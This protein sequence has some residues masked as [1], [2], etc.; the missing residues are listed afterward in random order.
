M[1]KMKLNPAV[2]SF[3]GQLGQMVHRQLWGQHVVS[4]A[5]DFSDRQLTDKQTA[6]TD[7][8]KRAGALWRSFPPEVKAAYAAF[9]KK[10]RKPPYALFNCNFSRPP[11]VDE[12]DLAQYTGAA[13]QV[14]RVRATDFF[15]VKS[16][17]VTVR[18]AGGSVWESGPATKDELEPGAWLYQTKISLPNPTGLTVEAIAANWPGRTGH[19][20]EIL[21]DR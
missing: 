21:R 7:R 11:A 18:E 2:Q 16:V 14:I 17:E 12:I 19:R 5:P 1:A 8:F 6:E 20:V 3:T 15:E 13:G 10:L 9:G 4:S